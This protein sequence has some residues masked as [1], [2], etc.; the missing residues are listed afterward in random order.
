MLDDATIEQLK[1]THGKQLAMVST[2]TGSDLVFR[3]PKRQEYNA[4]NDK[5]QA[6]PSTAAY[7]MALQCIVHPGQEALTAALD[8]QPA[9]LLQSNGVLDA[10]TDLANLGVKETAPQKKL[11]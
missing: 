9:L 10:I 3:K 7:N 5:A 4:W 2:S 1:N 6:E 8:A 11:L